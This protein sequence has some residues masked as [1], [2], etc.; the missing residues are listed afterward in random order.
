MGLGLK[1]LS[2][3]PTART[4]DHSHSRGQVGWG[5]VIPHPL[6]GQLKV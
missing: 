3:Q 2:H 1:S 6:L 5:T 4:P